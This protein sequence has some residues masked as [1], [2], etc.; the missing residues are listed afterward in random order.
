M[1]TKISAS[2]RIKSAGKIEFN[3]WFGDL[4]NGKE[5]VKLITKKNTGKILEKVKIYLKIKWK[6]NFPFKLYLKCVMNINGK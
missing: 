4:Q 2:V 1:Y 3:F 5:K 6:C